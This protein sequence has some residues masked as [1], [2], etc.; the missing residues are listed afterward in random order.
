[1]IK[2]EF[3]DAIGESLYQCPFANDNCN[4]DCNICLQEKYEQLE[5]GEYDESKD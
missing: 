5:R 4:K 2:Q 3:W 1:M